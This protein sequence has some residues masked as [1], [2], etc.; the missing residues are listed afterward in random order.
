MDVPPN[1]KKDRCYTNV[2]GI[3]RKSST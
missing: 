2:G 1:L 3:D